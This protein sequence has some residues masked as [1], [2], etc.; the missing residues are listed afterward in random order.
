MGGKRIRSISSACV[1]NV[2]FVFFQQVELHTDLE[3]KFPKRLLKYIHKPTWAVYPNSADYI[4][5]KVTTELHPQPLLM[6]VISKDTLTRSP[7]FNTLRP[8]FGAGHGP[9]V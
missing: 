4:F 9:Y 1:E 2:S 5:Q 7:G 3:R 6:S 8:G